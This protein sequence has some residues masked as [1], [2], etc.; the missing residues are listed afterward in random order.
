MRKLFGIRFI[1]CGIM[2]LLTQVIMFQ[3]VARGAEDG[4][5]IQIATVKHDGPDDFESALRTR[6]RESKSFQ[7]KFL[8]FQ[9]D[10]SNILSPHKAAIP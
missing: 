6:T 10:D 4:Q 3:D 7:R 8:M 5:A 9:R 1:T 2:G